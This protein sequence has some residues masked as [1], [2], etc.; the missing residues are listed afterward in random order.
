MLFHQVVEHEAQM[1]SLL[2][3]SE[4]GELGTDTNIDIVH[5]SDLEMESAIA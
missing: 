2:L 5:S 3:E 1:M 4:M